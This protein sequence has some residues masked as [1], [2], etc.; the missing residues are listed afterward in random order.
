MNRAK[1]WRDGKIVSEG[2]GGM[3]GGQTHKMSF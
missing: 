1:R 2:E 3:Y